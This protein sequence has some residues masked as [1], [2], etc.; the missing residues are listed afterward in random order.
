MV[1]REQLGN[2]TRNN[3][4][5]RKRVNLS[6]WFFTQPYGFVEGSQTLIFCRDW[7]YCQYSVISGSVFYHVN[8]QDQSSKFYTKIKLLID[9][10]MVE[11]WK[12][13]T[14]LKSNFVC[15]QELL[16][17]N[18]PWKFLFCWIIYVYIHNCGCTYK[19]AYIY[20]HMYTYVHMYICTYIHIYIYTCMCVVVHTTGLAEEETNLHSPG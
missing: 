20:T 6:D 15:L 1:W 8:H 13:V 4:K 19:Q 18:V 2:V 17:F 7:Q 14:T 9:K 10:V 11:I 3:W 5:I 16:F 12:K